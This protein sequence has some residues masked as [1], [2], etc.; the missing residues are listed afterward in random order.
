MLW[1]EPQHECANAGMLECANG[2]NRAMMRGRGNEW[3]DRD[4]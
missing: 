2:E 4:W 1:L 3:E